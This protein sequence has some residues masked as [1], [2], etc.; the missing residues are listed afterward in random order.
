MTI[1]IY[2]YYRN[3]KSTVTINSTF[4]SKNKVFCLQN[5]ASHLQ[6]SGCSPQGRGCIPESTYLK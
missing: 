3:I 5:W 4:I 2:F 6:M 1:K